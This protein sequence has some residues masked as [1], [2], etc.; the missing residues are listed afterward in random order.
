MATD[1]STLSET[2]NRTELDYYSSLSPEHRTANALEMLGEIIDDKSRFFALASSITELLRPA[3]GEDS[4]EPN[5]FRL[6][7]VLEDLVADLA[8]HYRLRDCIRAMGPSNAQ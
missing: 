7:E 5:A 6:S 8:Q 1:D 4:P 2:R 3:P